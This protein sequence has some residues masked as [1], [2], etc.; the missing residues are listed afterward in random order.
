MSLIFD[1]VLALRLALTPHSPQSK[2]NKQ[3]QKQTTKA[4]KQEASKTF[5]YQRRR[6]TLSLGA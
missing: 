6:I 5:V 2:Q 4:K 1:D 3:K